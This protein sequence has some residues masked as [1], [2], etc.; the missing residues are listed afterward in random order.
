MDPEQQD[1]FGPGEDFDPREVVKTI[2]NVGR[3]RREWLDAKLKSRANC[4][5]LPNTNSDRDGDY[6]E[7]AAYD[8]I[9][10]EHPWLDSYGG[11]AAID[12]DEH[13]GTDEGVEAFLNDIDE[14]EWDSF[15]DHVKKLKNGG[16]DVSEKAW[17]LAEADFDD[18]YLSSFWPD[19]KKALREAPQ[20]QDSFLQ[21]AVSVAHPDKGY[22][23]MR[24]TDTFYE[25][26]G[27]GVG[28]N[29]EGIAQNL[30]AED[31]LQDRQE[32]DNSE[33]LR[34]RWEQIKR[35]SWTHYIR[36]A[37]YAKLRAN[38]DTAARLERMGGDDDVYK[39]ILALIPDEN[40]SAEGGEI[41]WDKISVPHSR[42]QSKYGIYA[43]TDRWVP[44]LD[45]S[46]EDAI[47]WLADHKAADPRQMLMKL[48]S[49][50]E[51]VRRLVEDEDDDFEAMGLTPA[52]YAKQG[53]I[54]AY[55]V[56][57]EDGNIEIREPLSPDTLA[58]WIGERPYDV[59]SEDSWQNYLRWKTPLVAFD[60]N[61]GTGDLWWFDE[62]YVDHVLKVHDNADV[63]TLMKAYPHLSEALVRYFS[64]KLR[65]EGPDG[66]EH[67]LRMI[68]QAG[69][70][71]ALKP[72]RRYVKQ[73]LIGGYDFAAGLDYA[74]RGNVRMARKYLTT[75]S[76]RIEKDGFWTLF[77]DLSDTAGLFGEDRQYN[78][79]KNAQKLFNGDAHD[80][81]EYVW[82]GDFDLDGVQKFLKPKH[83]AE[84]RKALVGRQV[85]FEDTDETVTL[86]TPFLNQ[87]KDGDIFDWIKDCESDGNSD[88]EPVKEALD[89][90]LRSA[91]AD[92][93]EAATHEGFVSAL[94]DAI[95][96]TDMKWL[97]TGV[98]NKS[99]SHEYE[100]Q[101]VGFFI[102]WARVS[103]KLAKYTEE[104][105]D[106]YE[107][108]LYDLVTD[109][110]EKAMPQE[111][112]SWN[113]IT[114]V[115]IDDRLDYHL[116]ELEPVEHAEDPNQMPLPME[117]KTRY[118]VQSLMEGYDYSCMMIVLPKEH[119]DFIQRWSAQNILDGVLYH[120]PK[121]DTKGRETETHITVKWGIELAEPDARL[122]K[123]VALT[124]AFPVKLGKV[125]LFQQEAYDVVKIDVESP[126]LRAMNARVRAAV[127]NKET[128]PAYHPH[129]TLA[130]V[131]KGTCDQLVGQDL[132]A[133]SEVSPVFYVYDVR[134]KGPGEKAE[135]GPDARVVVDM[136]LAKGEPLLTE[137]KPIDVDPFKDFPIADAS[138]FFRSRRK[139]LRPEPKPVL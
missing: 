81:F 98:K 29:V 109:Y 93:D 134:F 119:A 52:Q 42:T 18:Q 77:N 121:D 117:S 24:S 106:P 75:Q 60:K 130:Y 127:P 15:K 115:N 22:D 8:L 86:T 10:H 44:T 27:N 83:W 67:N 123:L 128:H 9:E 71:A 76:V 47:D 16:F 74:L 84:I 63:A 122:K 43:M 129:M 95:G 94:K 80:W 30:E 137:A 46:F 89:H 21:F 120:D 38:P 65:A 111:E 96:A 136:P 5:I 87:F 100:E 62:T 78:W 104:N 56:V 110:S 3:E 108:S 51:V 28:L 70:P 61:S 57:Y 54:G 112:Y 25:M 34:R 132:F 50:S 20:L 13:G 90:A 2:F 58:D 131:Q 39:S 68:M 40:F 33:R 103:D 114:D 99:G 133:V 88:L 17:K 126:W 101:K 31:V 91:Q 49:A 37:Y 45:G 26:E 102:P 12:A 85:T 138:R 107:G 116:G 48:E 64:Q 19:I 23:W 53:G 118:L 69:G 7:R 35:L 105:L 82:D 41:Q 135:G 11:A 124:K 4:W 1:V 66:R 72:Y 125:S 14:D 139:K 55:R 73:G 36:K 6:H 59:R 79:V 113:K 97:K 32:R 92:A